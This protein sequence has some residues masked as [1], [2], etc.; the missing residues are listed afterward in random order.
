MIQNFD[1]EW[2]DM[3]SLNLPSD[4]LSCISYSSPSEEIPNPLTLKTEVED[5]ISRQAKADLQRQKT[6][7]EP[8]G[9]F[10][11]ESSS[12][13][14]LLLSAQL[15]CLRYEAFEPGNPIQTVSFKRF[16]G[17]AE[18]AGLGEGDQLDEDQE[19]AILTTITRGLLEKEELNLELEEPLGFDI[20]PDIDGNYVLMEGTDEKLKILLP[21]VRV[22]GDKPRK[23]PVGLS[24]LLSLL[25]GDVAENLKQL[26][27]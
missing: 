14:S 24:A 1:F 12:W 27:A 9:E 15:N 2:K 10:S 8:P 19:I 6:R 25:N 16:A 7:E 20:I 13:K 18:E 11:W 17:L 23:V 4:S 5:L 21:Y 22:T 26:L 3:D